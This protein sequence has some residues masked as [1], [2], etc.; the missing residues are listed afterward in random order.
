MSGTQRKKTLE[1]NS[2]TQGHDCATEGN[3][4]PGRRAGRDT[5]TDAPVRLLAG[6]TRPMSSEEETQLVEAL[7]ELLVEWVE[8]RPQRL[9]KG[10]RMGRGC[11]L[12]G[13]SQAKEQP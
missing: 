13:C 12:D 1:A 3:R 5:G 2:S 10:L 6:S 4:R 7:R 11:D 8:A 9:P